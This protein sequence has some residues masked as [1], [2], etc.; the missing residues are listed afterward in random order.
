MKLINEKIEETNIFPARI[1]ESKNIDFAENLMKERELSVM[2]GTD[3]FTKF[4]KKDSFIVLDF[5]K[6]IFGS[7]RIITREAENG[8]DFRITFGESLSECYSN[9]GEKNATNDHSPRDFSVNVPLMSDLKFASTGFRFVKIELQSK[10]YALVQSITAVSQIASFPFEAKIKTNDALLNKIIETAKYTLKLNLQNGYIW[11]GI[12]RDRLVWSGDLHQE[13]ITSLYCFGNIENI[14]N[15]LSLLKNS[16][17]PT[18]WMNWMPSYSAW[19]VINLC[20]YC[21]ISG[22]LDYFEQNK[23]YALATL[24]NIEKSIDNDGNMNFEDTVMPFFLDWPTCETKDAE[25]GTAALL[26]FAAKK[27]L[28]FE[29]SKVCDNIISKLEKYLYMPCKT[30]QVKAFQ[31][32]SGAKADG[33]KFIENNGV[34]GFSTF[35]TYYIL[36]AYI[37]SGGEKSIEMIKKYFGGMI[38]RGATTFWEDFDISWLNGSGRI[39]T[40]PSENQKDIHGDYGRFC[41]EGFRHSLCHGWSSGVLS[42]IIENIIGLKLI[43]G[44][45]KISVEPNLCGLK[46]IN[47]T[48]P[49]PY[50][51]LF[52]DIKKNELKIKSPKNIIIIN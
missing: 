35:M 43:D 3:G 45:K 37:K 47:A 8:A 20:D 42:F 38:S 48:I 4:Q 18:E 19:W 12:K 51:K 5:G 33:V 24:E 29:S 1:I 17:K 22:N 14:P 9:I 30:K 28:Y 46:H 25:I 40:L 21:R 44:F 52:I 36:S 16:T 10:N 49:T 50:G 34:N 7:I 11:D 41:Y 15:S 32:I 39:D 27:Y 31:I 26:C 2:F 23:E 13:I 6:E